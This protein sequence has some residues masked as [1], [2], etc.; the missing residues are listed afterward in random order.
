[1]R[2]RLRHLVLGVVPLL[3]LV[4]APGQAAA[5][6]HPTPAVP[7]ASAQDM[8]VTLYGFPDNSHVNLTW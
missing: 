4:L 2:R 1:M 5:G 7:R 6:T 3:L 8:L